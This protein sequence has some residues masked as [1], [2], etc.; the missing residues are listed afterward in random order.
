MIKLT[1]NIFS[2][3]LYVLYFIPKA[4]HVDGILITNLAHEQ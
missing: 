3:Y 4:K 2:M 1:E